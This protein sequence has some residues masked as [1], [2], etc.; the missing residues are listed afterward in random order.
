MPFKTAPLILALMSAVAFTMA[1]ISV[2][3]RLLSIS[4][5]LIG[6][7]A[8]GMLVFVSARRLL[9]R[10]IASRLEHDRLHSI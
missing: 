3:V 1:F 2:G 6:S 10:R 8:L 7:L 4:F 9:K 5:A